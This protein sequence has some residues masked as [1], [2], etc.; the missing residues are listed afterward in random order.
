MSGNDPLR[1]IRELEHLGSLQVAA[2]MERL[3]GF[4][5]LDPGAHLGDLGLSAAAQQDRRHLRL[6]AGRLRTGHPTAAP[7][8]LATRPPL[9]WRRVGALPRLPPAVVP[10]RK[11]NP[12]SR[13]V[14]KVDALINLVG[15]LVITQAMLK[16]VSH[17]LDPV[18]ACS[19][20]WT[21]LNATPATCRKR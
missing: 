13:R 8:S 5:Q 17:A 6:G 1:I 10:A 15:E 9:R 11:R 4:A 20:A 19:P 21:S 3:P 16:Q 2:R 12:R 14:D 7:P 18:H